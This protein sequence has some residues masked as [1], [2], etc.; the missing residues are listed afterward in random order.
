MRHSPMLYLALA[1]PFEFLQGVPTY[2]LQYL[3]NVILFFTN[4]I[5]NDRFQRTQIFTKV[6]VGNDQE[7]EQ[8]ERN[9]H[10]KNRSGEK[11]KLTI[12][13]LY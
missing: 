11:T 3:F 4:F 7:M 6:E 2:P 13:Y 5:A 8:S 9:S 10:S 12:R 1:V